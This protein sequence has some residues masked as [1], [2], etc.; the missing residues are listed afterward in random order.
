MSRNRPPRDLSPRRC[1]WDNM[2]MEQMIEILKSIGLP[3]DEI[4]RVSAYYGSDIDGMKQYVLY[5]K[6]MFD[7]RHE[8]IS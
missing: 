4:T 1:S 6:A 5:M 7:D 2:D 3:A 8:Y